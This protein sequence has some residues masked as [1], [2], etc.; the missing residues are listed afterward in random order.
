MPPCKVK[1]WQCGFCGKNYSNVN[2]FFRHT[3][4]KNDCWKHFQQTCSENSYA[5]P[6]HD[7]VVGQE[8]V[9]D[10]SFDDNEDEDIN[11]VQSVDSDNEEE[12]SEVFPSHSQKVSPEG[13]K[14][15][16]GEG[17][18]STLPPRDEFRLSL[19]A[20]LSHP[21][22]PLYIFSSVM[23]L[24]NAAITSPDSKMIFSN[25]Y[26][27]CRST[28]KKEVEKCFPVP[29]AMSIPFRLETKDDGEKDSSL[30]VFNIKETILQEVQH[31]DLWR[32]R[33][34][35]LKGN[36]WYQ[37]HPQPD[38]KGMVDY[39]NTTS[40][41]AYAKAYEKYIV[42][43]DKELL[44]PFVAWIDKSGVTGNLRHPVQPL[45]VKCLLLK[46]E[47]QR[48]CPLAYIPCT[49]KSSAENKQDS[50]SE[51]SRGIN[52]RNFHAALSMV[53][54][55][56][57]ETAAWFAVN[58]QQV[59]LG[60]STAKMVIKP[61]ILCFLGDHKSQLMLSC[62]YSNSVC[63]QCQ[64]ANP[65]SADDHK[66]TLKK[67]VDTRAIRK[68]NLELKELES[69]RAALK[70]RIDDASSLQKKK[71]KSKLSNVVTKHTH[72]KKKL[73]T[74]HVIPCDNAFSSFQHIARPINHCTPADH[75]HVFLLGILKTSALCT[76]GNFTDKQKKGLDDLA[77]Q[78]F[79]SNS[80]SARS[81]F[82]RFY[83]EKGMTN[84][85][86][87]TGQKWKWK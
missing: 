63:S 82:P 10:F 48:F 27:V 62:F 35:A 76:I 1:A 29:K 36:R 55:K 44:V 8:I 77:R 34:L 83:I 45:L 49:T 12:V 50:S 71:L 52:T 23:R 33:N 21:S 46:K 3:N 20:M 17:M 87:L 6:Q 15:M 4:Q 56:W 73:K 41:K 66:E 57:D 51:I 75:L 53:F 81:L 65:W 47:L 60:R 70:E 24:I 37:H 16:L 58:P 39:S 11:F 78:L 30:V 43:P 86:N 19:Y 5:S 64:S 84:T 2:S 72:A 28:T 13:I 31:P 42:D 14:A 67:F 85:G 61:V 59:T 80:S 32:R 38:G 69:K 74:Y 26:S 54:R 9:D 79:K 22:V 18:A 40:G 68:Y 7:V 25:T